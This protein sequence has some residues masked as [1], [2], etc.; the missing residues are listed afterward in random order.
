MNQIIEREKI[1]I[2]INLKV[3]SEGAWPI[4]TIL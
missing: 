2:G 1:T 4:R 3:F